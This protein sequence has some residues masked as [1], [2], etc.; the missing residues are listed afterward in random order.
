MY[1]TTTVSRAARSAAR[2]DP[3]RL[4]SF[5]DVAG[6]RMVFE[7]NKGAHRTLDTELFVL[8]PV[9]S[10]QPSSL[11]EGPRTGVFHQAP[12]RSLHVA[13]TVSGHHGRALLLTVLQDL[14]V[15]QRLFEAWG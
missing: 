9:L 5:G 13:A 12:R 15:T 14:S 6:T 2:V 7:G 10:P 11:S 3:V 4:G 8:S 1:K